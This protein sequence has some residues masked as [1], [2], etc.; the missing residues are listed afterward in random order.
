[1]R[2]LFDYFKTRLKKSERE[3][4]ESFF[5]FLKKGRRNYQVFW[6]R[7]LKNSCKRETDNA[8][9]L[10]RYDLCLDDMLRDID[11]NILSVYLSPT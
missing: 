4:I 1:V 7:F 11:L 5:L 10:G 3:R 8:R 2:D 9:G 6:V